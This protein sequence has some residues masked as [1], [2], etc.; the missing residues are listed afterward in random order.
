[1]YLDKIM[2]TDRWSLIGNHKQREMVQETVA[3][4]RAFACALIGVLWVHYREVATTSP[5]GFRQ[6]VGANGS[7]GPGVCSR[8]KF[9]D[10]T[11]NPGS[12]YLSLRRAIPS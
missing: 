11:E 3:L 8:Q 7:K 6:D 4:Y 1:M 10:E 2:R 9:R 5:R 12:H